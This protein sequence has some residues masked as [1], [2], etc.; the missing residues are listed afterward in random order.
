MK[1]TLSVLSRTLITHS[2]IA[3]SLAIAASY[4]LALLFIL[5]TKVYLNILTLPVHLLVKLKLLPLTALFTIY[6]FPT[7]QLLTFLLISLFVGANIE[8]LRQKV[9][10]LSKQKHIKFAMSAGILSIGG[11]GCAACGFSLLSVIGLGSAVSVLPFKGLGLSVVALT[12][13]IITFYYNATSFTKA[14][15]IS[16]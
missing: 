11:V 14:C 15:E 1:Y 12:I 9:H 2:F 5:D 4:F 16:S 13:L 8:L 10:V 7:L 6:N 3:R